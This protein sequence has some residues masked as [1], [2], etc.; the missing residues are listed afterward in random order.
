MEKECSKC[1]IFR[2]HKMLKT[3][4]PRF[5]CVVCHREYERE[6]YRKRIRDEEE[7][8]RVN[9]RRVRTEANLQKIHQLKSQPCT[10]CGCT[11]P[12]VSMDFDHISNKI[13]G[14]S[15]MVTCSW[16][17]IQREIEKCELVC[18]NCHRVRTWNR[19]HNS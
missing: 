9:T 4:H 1:G 12:P 14:I 10:D 13:K 11:F 16:E 3:G 19:L 8:G 15:Y 18:A 6:Y 17:S 7:F 2:E 5:L